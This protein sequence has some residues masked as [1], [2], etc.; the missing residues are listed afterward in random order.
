MIRFDNATSLNVK[1]CDL[2]TV[3]VL[4]GKM[5]AK[6]NVLPFF[7]L[8]E[9]SP[10]ENIESGGMNTA[11]F[12]RNVFRAC[13]LVVVVMG[14]DPKITNFLEQV[15]GSYGV[16][17][18]WMALVPVFPSYQIVLNTLEDQ[19]TWL[20]LVAKYPVVQ[21]I[22]THSRARFA[23]YFME[24]VVESVVETSEVELCRLLDDACAHVSLRTHEGKA[25]LNSKNGKYAQLMAISHSNAVVCGENE[26]ESPRKKTRLEVGTIGMHLHFANLIDDEVKNMFAWN[27]ALATNAGPWEP[28]C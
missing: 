8:D 2:K 14:T 21:D 26:E 13:G 7:V 9:M 25:F 11:A 22:V 16:Q 23:R 15:K 19:Q 17:H 18:R 1:P 20:K 5:K 24:R 28:K 4:I 6:K 12:Q 10:N 3:R 27:E